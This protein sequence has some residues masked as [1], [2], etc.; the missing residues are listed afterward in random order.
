MKTKISGKMILFI[1][2]SCALIV[3]GAVVGT[4]C[5]TT[6]HGFFN[7]GVEYDSAKSVSVT[8]YITDYPDISVVEKICEEEFEKQ[9]I[10]YRYE[11][12]SD[13]YGE[14]EY[15]FSYST[16]DEKL[17][18]AVYGNGID[19]DVGINNR[20]DKTGTEEGGGINIASVVV[21]EGMATNVRMFKYAAIAAASMMAVQALYCLIRFRLNM[22]VL[23]LVSN[24]H[25]VLL[26]LALFA[27]FRVPFSAYTAGVMIFGLLLAMILNQIFYSGMKGVLKSEEDADLSFKEKTDKAYA[28]GL[29]ASTV[30]SCCLFALGALIALVMGV[31]ARSATY[32]FMGLAASLVTLVAFYGSTFFSTSVYSRMEKIT[33]SLRGHKKDKK[34]KAGKGAPEEGDI[35]VESV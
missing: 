21:S 17:A 15:T 4:V 24:V 1:I 19:D 35:A 29:K 30:L 13:T 10:K 20:I 25:C 14:I 26:S 31:F 5:E 32:A 8:Y 2:I 23:S 18:A 6:G 11:T 34:E 33:V 7:Y 27:A 16:D 9:G 22:L 3:I 12:S 28:G